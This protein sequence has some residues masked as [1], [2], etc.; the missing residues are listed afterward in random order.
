MA[1]TRQQVPNTPN[2][3]SELNTPTEYLA[4][5][6]KLIAE[7]DITFKQLE[8]RVQVLREGRLV[9]DT[10]LDFVLDAFDGFNTQQEPAQPSFR[11]ALE[12]RIQQYLDRCTTP[13]TMNYD[14]LYDL[15]RDTPCTQQVPIPPRIVVDGYILKFDPAM[16]LST[17]ING[18]IFNYIYHE[19]ERY[20]FT[21]DEEYGYFNRI[22]TSDLDYYVN[23]NKEQPLK[24]YLSY[25]IPKPAESKDNVSEGGSVG[26]KEYVPGLPK[27]PIG[28]RGRNVKRLNYQ[29][30]QVLLKLNRTA[31]LTT[32]RSYADAP[33][34]NVSETVINPND[35]KVEYFEGIELCV[36]K[37]SGDT[38]PLFL[39]GS[40]EVVLSSVSISSLVGEGHLSRKK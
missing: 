7:G 37:H 15:T 23:P 22:T 12:K 33:C 10:L 28:Y 30:P 13:V 17:V 8:A 29:A 18:F 1:V 9:A 16:V 32:L 3:N 36:I 14:I 38:Y 40:G 2:A 5:I 39:L 26:T 19:N 24:S 11:V 25:L 31:Q 34:Y 20:L 21:H 6:T 35:V 4:S 27:L